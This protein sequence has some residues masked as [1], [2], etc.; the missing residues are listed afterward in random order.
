MEVDHADSS[1][2]VRR[3]RLLEIYLVILMVGCRL[4]GLLELVCFRMYLQGFLGLALC[5]DGSDK[6]YD[7]IIFQMRR[8][9]ARRR[10]L[11]LLLFVAAF[12]TIVTY[13]LSSLPSNYF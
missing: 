3:S 13:S 10:C 9:V 12:T 5:F 4:L 7:L 11:L 1:F 2:L 6:K 8:H